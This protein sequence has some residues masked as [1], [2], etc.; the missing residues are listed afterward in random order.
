MSSM[1]KCTSPL[2]DQEISDQYQCKEPPTKKRKV[3]VGA[4]VAKASAA[5]AELNAEQE[6]ATKKTAGKPMNRKRPRTWR[7]FQIPCHEM[8]I[9]KYWRNFRLV[10]FR[11]L[12][13]KNSGE[14]PKIVLDSIVDPE[15]KHPWIKVYLGTCEAGGKVG[16]ARAKSRK[17]AIRLACLDIIQQFDLVP[18]ETFV[19]TMALDL[20]TPKQKKIRPIIEYTSY[21]RGNY[22]GALDEYARKHF[23]PRKLIFKF[24]H[25]CEGDE[26]VYVASCTTIKGKYVGR[27][28]S[29]HKKRSAHLACL[30]YMLKS[31]LLTKEQ[32]LEKHPNAAATEKMAC[33]RHDDDE[34][35]KLGM[36]T[37]AV[38]T[39]ENV[40]A[41]KQD[42]GEPLVATGEA[43]VGQ[44]TEGAKEDVA[45]KKLDES[46]HLLEDK[47]EVSHLNDVTEEHL[48][49]EKLDKV[50]SP[51]RVEDTEVVKQDT[52]A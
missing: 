30:D 23:R 39:Q 38:H 49:L 44:P 22:K 31:E 28:R 45:N 4:V 21:L 46:N 24:D 52:T 33:E 50:I 51:L 16:K 40:T 25:F 15:I 9:F 3:E 10:L 11:Y 41:E 20:P 34:P 42:Q 6:L 35:S 12:H 2:A 32:H 43:E 1:T 18:K 37:A 13:W 27:G 48:T 8:P 5:S 47:A 17:E 7:K 29:N 36:K 26:K 14:D 19:D